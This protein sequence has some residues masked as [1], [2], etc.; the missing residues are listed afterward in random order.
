MQTPQRTD[1][2]KKPKIKLT[3]S[4]PKV[5]NGAAST[6]KS[7]KAKDESKS[8][9]SKAK[10]PAAEETTEAT[11]EPELTPEERHARKEVGPSTA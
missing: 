4:T 11:T 5:T 8:T 2:V 10:K 3:S 1:S 9:K 6:P 7:S